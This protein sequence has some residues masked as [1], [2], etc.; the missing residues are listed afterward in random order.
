L[1]EDS[2]VIENG[3]E[4]YSVNSIDFDAPEVIK[5]QIQQVIE[6]EIKPV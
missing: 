1:A 6:P 3:E 2:E 5:P 4:N